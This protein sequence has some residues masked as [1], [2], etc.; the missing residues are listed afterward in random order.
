M[1]LHGRLMPAPTWLMVDCTPIRHRYWIGVLQGP[2]NQRI[3][4][5]HSSEAASAQTAHLRT[6]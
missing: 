3:L 2:W 5:A 1:R 6:S 4:P